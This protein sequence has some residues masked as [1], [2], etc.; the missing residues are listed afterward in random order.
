[1]TMTSPPSGWPALKVIDH[2]ADGTLENCSR[3]TNPLT[4]PPLGCAVVDFQRKVCD[5]WAMAEWVRA[6]ELKHC[7]GHDHADETTLA[8]AWTRYQEINGQ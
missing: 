5:V 6:E 3:Y 7:A 4:W 8:D 2:G 1:M